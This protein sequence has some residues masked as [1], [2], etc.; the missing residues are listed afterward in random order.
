MG[1]RYTSSI[2]LST[3]QRPECSKVRWTI[4]GI[5]PRGD[6][7][8]EGTRKEKVPEKFLL[9]LLFAT[10]SLSFPSEGITSCLRR[11]YWTTWCTDRGTTG[12]RPRRR[13]VILGHPFLEL[14][15]NHYDGW[16]Q[17]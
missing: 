16:L 8:R 10:D 11:R 1:E 13:Q 5:G 7:V 12:G 14:I 9:C 6:R 17:T 4:E 3:E 2:P 15:L